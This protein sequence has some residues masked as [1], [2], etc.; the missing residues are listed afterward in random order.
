MSAST[1]NPSKHINLKV[2][3]GGTVDLI[4]P[5][6]ILDGTFFD[7]LD[8]GVPDSYIFSQSTVYP[9]YR[10]DNFQQPFEWCDDTNSV[11]GSVAWNLHI[12]HLPWNANWFSAITSIC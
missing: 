12:P 7:G 2:G 5:G 6:Y 9:A 10:V 11:S 8:L 1:Q 3:S 4:V